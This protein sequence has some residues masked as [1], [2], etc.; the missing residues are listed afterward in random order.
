MIY[1]KIYL[2]IILLTLTIAILSWLLMNIDTKR[3][4]QWYKVS[5]TAWITLCAMTIGGMLIHIWI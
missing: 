5:M 1:L 2:T 4:D 3:I